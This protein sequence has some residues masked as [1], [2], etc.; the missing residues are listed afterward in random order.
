VKRLLLL[1]FFVSAISQFLA[2]EFLPGCGT[3]FS[4]VAE[5]VCFRIAQAMFGPAFGSSHEHIVSAFGAVLSSLSVTTA[6]TLGAVIAQ[7]LGLFLSTRRLVVLF[8]VCLSLF[9]VL[10]FL[11]FPLER[12]A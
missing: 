4:Y 11:A 8:A 2:I 9:L 3:A 1:T 5:M 7:K 6:L 10:V 12:C